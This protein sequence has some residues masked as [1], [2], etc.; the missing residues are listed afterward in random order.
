MVESTAI[1]HVNH[2]IILEM[3]NK[4]PDITSDGA[5]SSRIR[6]IIWAEPAILLM[7]ESALVGEY[8]LT[9]QKLVS[10]WQF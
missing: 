7:P 1:V 9:T 4:K 2:V 3:S 8:V 6:A 10:A 5:F